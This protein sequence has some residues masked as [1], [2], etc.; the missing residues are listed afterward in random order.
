ML[1]IHIPYFSLNENNLDFW[2]KFAQKGTDSVEKKE[3]KYHHRIQHT[4]I[5]F[6]VPNLSSNR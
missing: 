6:E 5:S 2:T 3:N 4:R 1:Y